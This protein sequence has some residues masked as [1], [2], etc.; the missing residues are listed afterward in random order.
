MFS[1]S[2]PAAAQDM[3]NGVIINFAKQQKLGSHRFW[4]DSL[5]YNDMPSMIWNFSPQFEW[6]IAF[7]NESTD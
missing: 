7:P 4:T 2:N 6:T 3:L 1:N 5:F